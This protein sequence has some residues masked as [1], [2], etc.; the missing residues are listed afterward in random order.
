MRKVIMWN[1]VTLDGFFEGP[2]S[3]DL[4]WHEYVWGEELERLSL[5]QSKSIGMLLFGRVTYEGMAGYWQTQKGEIADFMNEVPKVVFS[6]TLSKAEW[7]HTRLVRDQAEEEVIRLKKQPGKDLF[8]F[9]S[10]NLSSTFTR[11]G[12]IDEYR[13]C[14]APIVLGGGNPLFKPSPARLRLKLLEA[15]PLKSGGVILRYQPNG[16]K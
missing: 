12:L 11:A 3:W 16:Q 10:A 1:L 14:V 7:N 4:D 2:K 15:R 9:G 6:R 13:L 5:E 8:I